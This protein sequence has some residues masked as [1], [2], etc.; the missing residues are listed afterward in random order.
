MATPA[1]G[2]IREATERYFGGERRDALV[3]A[4]WGALNIAGAALAWHLDQRLLLVAL[5]IIG[6]LQFLPGLW[7]FRRQTARLAAAR[8]QLATEPDG[9]RASESDRLR[10]LLDARRRLRI[11]DVAFFAAFAAVVLLAPPSER[12]ARLAVPGQLVLL[13]LLNVTMERRARRFAQALSRPG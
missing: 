6:T 4:C 3:F 9:F 10:R 8:E 1:A 11:A 5:L 2:S 12:M 13:P 7:A